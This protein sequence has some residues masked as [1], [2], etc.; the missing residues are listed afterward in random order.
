MLKAAIAGMVLSVS[1]FVNAGLI[2]VGSYDVTNGEAWG[3]NPDVFSAVE[4]A[5][6]VFAIAVGGDYL[7]SIN[8]YDIDNISLT[9]W[10]TVFS[11]ALAFLLKIIF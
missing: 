5:E 10:Y 8:G 11:V 1:V 3:S 4:A 9:A 2:Y 6:E 7:T